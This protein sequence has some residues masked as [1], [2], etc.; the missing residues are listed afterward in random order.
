MSADAPVSAIDLARAQAAQLMS[1]I[2]RRTRRAYLAGFR[3]E[4]VSQDDVFGV[5]AFFV[6]IDDMAGDEQIAARFVEDLRTRSSPSVDRERIW[7]VLGHGSDP[8]DTA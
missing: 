7:I 5:Q 8:A 6:Q 4:R 3:E 1:T 2:R